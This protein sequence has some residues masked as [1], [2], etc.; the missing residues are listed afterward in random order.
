MKKRNLKKWLAVMMSAVMVMSMAGCGSSE[1]AA[2]SQAP[3]ET[4]LKAAEE[5]TAEE[6]KA[7]ET[8]D[9]SAQGDAQEAVTLPMPT[10]TRPEAMRKPCRRCMKPFMKNTPTLR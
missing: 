1:T 4:G 6:S 10:L 7:A 3:A 5:G 9:V 8:V 2:E